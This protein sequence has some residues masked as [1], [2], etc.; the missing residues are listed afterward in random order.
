MSE[1]ITPAVEIIDTDLFT[2]TPED[3]EVE[4]DLT[5]FVGN[6]TEGISETTPYGVWKIMTEGFK[7][8]GIEQNR[9]SQMLYNYTR[10][11]MVAKRTKGMKGSEVRYT[12]QEIQEFLVRFYTKHTA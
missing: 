2:G 6:L 1:N 4:F 12:N 3:L 5:T 9:P 7:A 10:N 11:G 8:L